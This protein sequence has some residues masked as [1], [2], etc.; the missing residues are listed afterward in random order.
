MIAVAARTVA[1]HGLIMPRTV[2]T[3]HIYVMMATARA[4]LDAAAALAIAAL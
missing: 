4:L 1:R 2:A 3:A